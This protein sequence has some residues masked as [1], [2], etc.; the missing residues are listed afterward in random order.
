MALPEYGFQI[1]VA[2]RTLSIETRPGLPGWRGLSRAQELL[3]EAMQIEPTDRVLDL[4]CG[5]GI[6]GLAATLVATEGH[7]TLADDDALAIVCSRANLKN[8]QIENATA[9]LTADY[10]DL[11]SGSYD[12]VLLHAPAY[13]GNAPVLRLIA[14]AHRVLRA[15]GCF[16][17]AGARREGM[18]TFQRRVEE[19]FG[20]VEVM[21]RGGGQRVILALKEAA[22]PADGETL[23]DEAIEFEVELW[24]HHFRFRSRPGVFAHGKVDAASRLLL[25]AARLDLV[26]PATGHILDLGCGYGLLGVVAAQLVPGAQVVLVDRSLLAG[27]CARENIAL[28]RI[29]N[30][31]VLVGDG[32]KPLKAQGVAASFDLILCNPPFHAGRKADRA[33]GERLIQEGANV[34]KKDGRFYV[35]CNEFLPYERVMGETLSQVTEIA[36]REGFKVLLGQ[37]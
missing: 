25:E 28:N 26:E 18:G 30:A 32:S 14:T 2:G 34:L 11:T 33:V 15:G 20:P 35:V 6:C 27:Q 37:S 1:E 29:P 22:G 31:E 21:A 12:V 36:R 16:Y 5:Y 3:I 9:Q 17:L 10:N 24:G 4:A 8:N 19:L 7:V 13:R 23:P